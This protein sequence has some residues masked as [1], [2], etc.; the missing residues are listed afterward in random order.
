[1]SSRRVRHLFYYLL[2]SLSV[3][4]FIFASVSPKFCPVTSPAGEQV[5]VA[6][7]PSKNILGATRNQCALQCGVIDTISGLSA[8]RQPG[9]RCFNYNSTSA[10]CS[11]FTLEPTSYGVDQEGSTSAY[12][13]MNLIENYSETDLHLVRIRHSCGDRCVD[14]QK[15][16]E[17]PD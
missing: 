14:A 7:T 3:T 10:N 12:Q 17:F 8:G 9:C 15:R 13:V 1:M 5:Y 11:I 2:L 4:P 16:F 6:N